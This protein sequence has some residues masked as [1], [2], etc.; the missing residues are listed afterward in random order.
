MDRPKLVVTG[1]SGPELGVGVENPAVVGLLA[2]PPL[3]A[4]LQLL[5]RQLLARGRRP[6][7]LLQPAKTCA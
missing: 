4:L 7:A 1:P 3:Q 2:D 6:E 5:V